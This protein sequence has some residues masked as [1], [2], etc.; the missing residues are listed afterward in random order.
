[1]A[2]LTR[3]HNDLVHYILSFLVFDLERL[4]EK[5]PKM[6]AEREMVFHHM[7]LGLLGSV[8]KQW[9]EW[10]RDRRY[11]APLYKAL[12]ARIE[13][14]YTAKHIGPCTESRCILPYP[15]EPREPDEPLPLDEVTSCIVY[16]DSRDHKE[17]CADPG[18]YTGA[19][20][21]AVYT[22]PDEDLPADLFVGCAVKLKTH[23]SLFHAG[24][25]YNQ[26]RAD[27]I[28]A[29]R[30]EIKALEL[31][32]FTGVSSSYSF[33][34]EERLREARSGLYTLMRIKKSHIRREFAF[35]AHVPPAIIRSSVDDE[36]IRALLAPEE[37]DPIESL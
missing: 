5:R 12:H 3:L 27:E 26:E 32:S 20:F 17:R 34:R 30:A 1:M 35:K 31:C 6:L 36:K 22:V 33:Q 13:P 23:P 7:G 10:T 15:M 16:G 21:R 14:D 19:M 2:I 37:I 25:F 28:V 11:W 18:H 9:L 24:H 4:A 8:S 29:L